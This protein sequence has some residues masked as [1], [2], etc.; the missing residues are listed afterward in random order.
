MT[1]PGGERRLLRTTSEPLDALK[2][3]ALER[4]LELAGRLDE[5]GR[6]APCYSSLVEIGEA[7]SEQACAL[8][9]LHQALPASTTDRLVFVAELEQPTTKLW[10]CHAQI[11]K[12]KVVVHYMD[13]PSRE[14][15]IASALILLA[16]TLLDKLPEED[17]IT[18]EAALSCDLEK[19]MAEYEVALGPSPAE[20]DRLKAES[21]ARSARG[22]SSVCGNPRFCTCESLDDRAEC[23]I[24]RA[25]VAEPSFHG[26]GGV[27]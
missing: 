20:L 8:A 11:P 22:A 18:A 12:E 3:M 26:T 27:D 14:V 23:T 13:G 7:V 9:G 15:A 17:T 24:L 10:D 19:A 5:I 25:T 6:M 2:Q 16:R 21:R 4:L 1:V